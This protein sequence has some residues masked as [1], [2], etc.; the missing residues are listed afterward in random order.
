LG[1]LKTLVQRFAFLS[2]IA[3]TFALMLIGKADT[4]LV[5]RA[6]V[7]ITDALVPILRVL[8]QPAN[9]VAET[10][11]NFRELAAIREQNSSLRDA[12]E[13]LLQW[14][15]IAQR[16]EAENRSLKALLALAPEPTAAFVS[17]R[18]VG[19]TGGAFAQSI[20]VTAGATDGVGKGDVVV[21]GEGLVGRV[22]QA[23]A[24]SSRVLLITDINSRIPVVVGEAQNRAILV[25]DN[26]LRPR[27]LY[28]GTK[29][30][31]TPGDKVMTSG[32]AEAFP[33]GLPVGRVARVQDGI[34]TVE[35]YVSRDKLQ[36]VRIVD[37]GLDGILDTT[38]PATTSQAAAP[39][40]ASSIPPNPAPA[41]AE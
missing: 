26:G 41:E 33:P 20:I 31:V 5:E 15:A 37:Y 3:L 39:R 13:R 18:V 16:L 2:L 30:V 8:S 28:T 24:R 11:G 34:I 22:L 29:T 6:R 17:A 35:P 40:A 36:H 10:I 7:A 4:V 25:G 27:L 32:D 1:T 19:D 9:A 14:Q 23:G 12:N 38:P 21:T